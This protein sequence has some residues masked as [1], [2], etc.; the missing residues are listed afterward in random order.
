[1][2]RTP[3]GRCLPYNRFRLFHKE[4]AEGID[5]AFVGFVYGGGYFLNINII[6]STNCVNARKNFAGGVLLLQNYG[7]MGGGLVEGLA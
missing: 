3:L 1:M 5:I 6:P 2:R 7:R 4:C